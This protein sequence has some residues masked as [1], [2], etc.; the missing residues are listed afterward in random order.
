MSQPS[1]NDP[2]AGVVAWLR[3]HDIVLPSYRKIETW[4]PLRGPLSHPLY[5]SLPTGIT[6]GVLCYCAD[7]S[8]RVVH[9]T[10]GQCSEVKPVSTRTSVNIDEN[11]RAK[12]RRSSK[13]KVLS[14]AELADLV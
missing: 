6:D 2:L 12:P 3:Q 11:A 10:L 14:S 1:N 7:V 8:G 4:R 9:V 5:G 13:T